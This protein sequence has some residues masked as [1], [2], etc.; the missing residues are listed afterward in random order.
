MAYSL[1]LLIVKQKLYTE[2]DKHGGSYACWHVIW[3]RRMTSQLRGK[4]LIKVLV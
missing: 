2:V 1:C 3:Q 4:R